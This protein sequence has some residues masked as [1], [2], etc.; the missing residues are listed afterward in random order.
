MPGVRYYVFRRSSRAI[1]RQ[2]SIAD[3]DVAIQA[4]NQ[5]CHLAI[6]RQF[7]SNVRYVS[8]G[9]RVKDSPRG[10]RTCSLA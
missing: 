4:A 6:F 5:H 3:D 8:L 1:S 9:E 2:E 7:L 10:K